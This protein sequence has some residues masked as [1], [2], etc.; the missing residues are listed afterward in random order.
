MKDFKQTLDVFFDAYAARTNDALAGKQ[1]DV[2]GVTNSFA[3]CFVEAS[4]KGIICGQNNDEFREGIPK[5]YDFYKSIGTKSMDIIH[6][7]ITL[8]DDMHAMVKIHW[9]ARHKKKDGT[10]V[11]IEFDV[12]YFVQ[13]LDKG[14][15]IFAYVTGDEQKAHKENGLI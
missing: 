11:D 7:E 12:F 5:G 9:V 13:E 6:K 2:S 8:L 1:P 4:P 3:G 15:R 10:A 14:P